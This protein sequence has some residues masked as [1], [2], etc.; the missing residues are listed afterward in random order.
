MKL[1]QSAGELGSPAAADRAKAQYY[2]SSD[3]TV[4]K[5]SVNHHGATNQYHL[6]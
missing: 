1:G 3:K 4:R 5:R 2:S 6:T